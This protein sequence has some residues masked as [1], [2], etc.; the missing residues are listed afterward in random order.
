[1]QSNPRTSNHAPGSPIRTAQEKFNCS[2]CT[3]LQLLEQGFNGSPEGLE[4]AAR[5]MYG[6]RAQAKALMQMPTEDGLA[7]AGP[8]FEYVAPDRRAEPSQKAAGKF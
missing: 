6:L 8:T 2:Y 5:T 4:A 3:L 1:M 7:T